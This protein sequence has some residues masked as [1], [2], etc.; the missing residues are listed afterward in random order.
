E[1]WIRPRTF[2]LA[3]LNESALR[4][5]LSQ[6]PSES[7][8][9]AWQRAAILTLPMPDGRFAHF[10]V[11]DSPIMAPELASR[12][13]QI[14]TYLGQGIDD[15]AAALRC[16]YTPQGFHAQILSPRGAVYLD[17]VSRGDT[18]HY[19]CYFKRD[20]DSTVGGLRCLTP[21]GQD[22]P[23]PQMGFRH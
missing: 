7:A 18:A 15:P 12:Y 22:D 2:Q 21:G 3:R 6:A 14:R 17:P 16:D 4:Q 19:A 5:L 11:V 10:R 20:Y 8:E 23:P 1:P 13:P 9:L